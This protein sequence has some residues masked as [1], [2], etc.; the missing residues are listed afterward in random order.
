LLAGLGPK[1]MS[2]KIR[3]VSYEAAVEQLLNACRR[4]VRP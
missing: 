3:A 2:V 4:L 1:P